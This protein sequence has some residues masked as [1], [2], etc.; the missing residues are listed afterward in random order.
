M[1]KKRLS[2]L[3]VLLCL[4]LSGCKKPPVASGNNTAAMRT[5]ATEYTA[6]T[7]APEPPPPPDA[8]PEDAGTEWLPI[9]QTSIT[10]WAEPNEKT[11]ITAIPKGT[12][13]ILEA[14]QG[15]FALVTCNHLKGYV[16]SNRIQPKDSD[17]FTKYLTVLEPTTTYTY[18]QMQADAAAL[19]E[20]YP[21]LVS[22]SSIGKSENGT[23][24]PVVKIGKNDAK[25]QVLI[26]AAIH[27]REHFTAWLAMALADH[28]LA[29][30]Q[31]NDEICYHIIPMSNPDGVE[32]SQKGQLNEEQE[33]IYWADRSYEYTYDEIGKYAV[34]WKANALGVDLNRNFPS[35]WEESDARVETS[36]E[37]YRG[38]APFSAKETQALRDYTL[39]NE[40]DVT[41]SLHSHGSVLYYQYGDKEPVN[42]LSYNLASAVQ[43]VTGYVP[44]A[45]DNTTGAGYKDWAMDE[46]G[47][48]SLTV[49]IG[50]F[51]TPMQQDDTYNTFD[52]C[53]QLLPTIYTW[54][55]E[56]Q[57]P[58]EE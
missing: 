30:D 33:K 36:S 22:L 2:I 21:D 24:I 38:D 58:A 57:T 1:V 51:E 46:L 7:S 25:Y 45:F 47:I 49:E 3:L 50:N 53:K 44:T 55:T 56:Q 26:Q 10:L 31:L 11:R 4:I 8:I 13:L 17:Y 27:G 32:I 37:G 20:L 5:E 23:D 39:A 41:L 15:K 52:R 28:A 19:K 9:C 12:T 34:Q 29:K 18:T 6:E 35:G 54:L 16:Y 14:W 43:K 42:N 40:F 48:P